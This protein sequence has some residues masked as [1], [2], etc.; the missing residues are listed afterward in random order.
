M[1]Y[2]GVPTKFYDNGVTSTYDVNLLDANFNYVSGKIVAVTDATFGADSTGVTDSSA[3]FTAALAYATNV[4]VYVP[5]GAY[6]LNSSVTIPAGCSLFG[7]GI[8]ATTINFHSLS[9][10]CFIFGGD[11]CSIRDMF[12]QVPTGTALA[13]CYG[14][15]TSNV[16]PSTSSH[17]NISRVNISAFYYGIYV[18]GSAIGN[19][20]QVNVTNCVS[21]GLVG[22]SAQGYWTN[23]NTQ[24]NGGDGVNLGVISSAAAPWITGLQSFNNGGWDVQSSDG[25]YL[26]QA[27]LNNSKSGGIHLSGA[28]SDYGYVADVNI[29]FSG[30]S[31]TYGVNTSAPAVKID[32]GTGPITFHDLHIFDPQGNGIEI[33]NDSN[34]FI[35]GRVLGCGAGAVAG[36]VFGILST[37]SSSNIRGMTF[38]SSCK[39]TGASNSLIHGNTISVSDATNPAL[40]I[41]SGTG[42]SVNGNQIN[43][44]AGG[45]VSFQADAGVTL[46]Y[47]TN[48]LLSGTV[49]NNAT[50]TG[51]SW[52]S[53]NTAPTPV[54]TFA[55]PGDLAVTYSVQ[56]MVRRQVGPLVFATVTIATSAFTYTTSSGALEITGLD[57]GAMTLA[58]AAFVGGM[59]YSNLSLS[60]GY[61]QVTPTL[62]TS[63]STIQFI[64][65]GSTK[66]AASITTT[67]APSATNL[68]IVLTM[69]YPAS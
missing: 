48:D 8:G 20:V 53:S 33:N 55:T 57:V 30:N 40:Y 34:I 43:N 9:T 27:F 28:S 42:V 44:A 26:I 2:Q 64:Q 61:S 47:G 69:V 25:I 7:A 10:A 22:N 3:A 31:T 58:G 46:V 68:T 56:Q 13:G 15:S 51:T 39:F 52:I 4:Q 5:P 35:G 6:R 65:S 38:G 24:G 18:N 29:Q 41:V 19:I 60:A 37:G 36:H 1:A 16:S 45:G 50:F 67:N 49:T 32:A 17:W 63:S 59:Y 12:I 21:H 23:I 14:I 62:N 11:N 54:L 66:A